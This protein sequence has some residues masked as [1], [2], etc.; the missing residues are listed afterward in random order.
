MQR[1]SRHIHKVH[2]STIDY[3]REEVKIDPLATLPRNHK[4]TEHTITSPARGGLESKLPPIRSSANLSP[5]NTAPMK[6]VQILLDPK[7]IQVPKLKALPGL[8]KQTS[9]SDD[10]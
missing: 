2:H 4:R 6:N 3:A 1:K 10:E 7:H 8:S 9:K 5:Q